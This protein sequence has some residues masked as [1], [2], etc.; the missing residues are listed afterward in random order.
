MKS[1]I[2]CAIL[3]VFLRITGQMPFQGTDVAKLYPVEVVSL[4]QDGKDIQ[5]KTDTEA[6]GRGESL[7]LAFAD[8]EQTA[9]GKIFLE[10]ANYLLISENCETLLPALKDY[11]RPACQVCIYKGDRELKEIG[12]FLESHPTGVALLDCT[13]GDV[14]LPTIRSTAGGFQYE[15]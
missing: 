10:T 1:I 5:V 3:A 11:L 14:E 8:M 15:K 9:K 4:S 13:L 6:Q 2:V 12:P 7:R